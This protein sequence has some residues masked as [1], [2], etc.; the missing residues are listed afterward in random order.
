MFQ[1]LRNPDII[2]PVCG[3]DEPK[4]CR[5]QVGNYSFLSCRKCFFDF[6]YPSVESDEAFDNYYWTS[7]YTD[8]FERYTRVTLDSLKKKLTDV[9]EII[10]RK[11]GSFLDVGCGNGLYLRAA[12]ELGIENLGIDID[13]VNIEFAKKMGLNALAGN[14]EDLSLDDRYDFIHLKSVLHLVKDPF[15]FFMKAKS[16]LSPGGVVFI[17]VPNQGSVFSRLRMIRD[18]TRY[19]QLELPL[20]RGAFNYRCLAY[21]CERAGLRIVKRVFIYPGD[22]VYY[23]ILGKNRIYLAVFRLFAALRISSLIGIYAVSSNAN[24]HES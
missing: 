12:D 14:L 19:G 4:I 11:A 24:H 13:R 1:D 16:L 5:R 3:G 7:D 15:R 10:G 2:C 6:I 22:R 18:R 20:R 8:R 23:P 9:E 21:L 17:D